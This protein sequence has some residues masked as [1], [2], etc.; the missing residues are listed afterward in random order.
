MK[1]QDFSSCLFLRCHACDT[2]VKWTVTPFGDYEAERLHLYKRYDIIVVAKSKNSRESFHEEKRLDY[3]R[4][5]RHDRRGIYGISFLKQKYRKRTGGDPSGR[6]NLW[7]LSV[8]QGA[9]NR[10]Q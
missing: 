4:R 8:K 9:D 5:D 3:D 1:R 6:R 10:N 2:N 7:N